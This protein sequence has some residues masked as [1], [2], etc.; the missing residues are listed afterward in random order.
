MPKRI[1]LHKTDSTNKELWRMIDNEAS[2]EEATV[3]QAG[4]QSEGRGQANT[5]W[6]SKQG[7]NLLFS[8]LLKPVFLPPSMQFALNQCIALSIRAGL[9]ALCK[10]YH[11][12]IKWPNDI[13]VEGRKIAGTLIENRIMGKE[14]SLSV[15]GIGINTNQTVFSNDIPNPVSL[16]MLTGK[17]WDTESCL[18]EVMKQLLFHYQKLQ[19][20]NM[21]YIR[22]Q[23]L[24]HLWGFQKKMHF[25]REGQSMIATVLGVDEN[26]KL[27]LENQQGTIK[28]FDIKEIQ[29]DPR[30]FAE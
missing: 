22:Q 3:V 4:W 9:A 27:L 28:A 1:Y 12:F 30:S 29:F 24:K 20:G 25:I 15:V 11:F 2:P 13:Y 6:E 26:G 23:Y 21:D 8:I 5:K 10:D 14:L 18:D 16:K 19:S 7:D 17:D